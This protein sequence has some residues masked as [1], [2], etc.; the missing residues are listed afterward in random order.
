MKNDFDVLLHLSR[1]VLSDEKDRE[2]SIYGHENEI[3]TH[4]LAGN[5]SGV[6]SCETLKGRLKTHYLVRAGDEYEPIGKLD[7]S[8]LDEINKES[9]FPTGLLPSERSIRNVQCRIN[10]VLDRLG[11]SVE[12]SRKGEYLV[13]SP[14]KA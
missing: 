14:K 1:I 13:F 10:D 6:L 2:V 3:Q 4:N 7:W 12:I 5:I 11:L 9:R 8:V